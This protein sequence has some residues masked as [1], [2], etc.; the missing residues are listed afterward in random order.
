M[1]V[2]QR[3]LGLTCASLAFAQAKYA[4]FFMIWGQAELMGISVGTITTKGLHWGGVGRMLAFQN[5]THRIKII[6][7]ATGQHIYNLWCPAAWGTFLLCFLRAKPVT[8]QQVARLRPVLLMIRNPTWKKWSSTHTL[9]TE[10]MD[11]I[12]KGVGKT[13]SPIN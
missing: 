1:K 5:G 12:L 10:D 7:A 9:E 2:L 3:D 4:K 6:E 11:L 8:N 13:F